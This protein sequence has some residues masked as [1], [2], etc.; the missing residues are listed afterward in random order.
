MAAFNPGT[1]GTLLSTSLE[2]AI[3]ELAE[4]S[5]GLDDALVTPTNN[6]G[7]V[8]DSDASIATIGL[9]LPVTISTSG[10]QL[11][12]TATDFL[13]GSVFA[14]GTGGDLSATTYPGALLE[15][16]TLLQSA[17]AGDADADNNVNITV[18]SDAGVATFTGS[19]P[20]VFAVSGTDGSISIQANPYIA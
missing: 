14:P 10:G 7:I 12:Y 16:A 15:L 8:Y 17:E 13:S 11:S 19:I 2:A 6:I 18:D 3:V 5:Q 4:A 9:A 1:G 20:I